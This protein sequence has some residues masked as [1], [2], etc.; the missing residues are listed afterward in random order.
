MYIFY[1]LFKMYQVLPK[2]LKLSLIYFVLIKITLEN[3]LLATDDI[4]K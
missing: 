2:K 1:L 3:K 4:I